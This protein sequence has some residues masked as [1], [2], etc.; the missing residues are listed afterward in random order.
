MSTTDPAA[1]AATIAAVMAATQTEPAPAAEPTTV[2][3]V[4]EAADRLKVSRPL[5]LA[6][7]RPQ[8]R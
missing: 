2:L 8:A 3:T 6:R 7:V 4:D 1:L 5:N